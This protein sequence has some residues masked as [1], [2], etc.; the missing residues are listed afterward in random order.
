MQRCRRTNAH[1]LSF[2]DQVDPCL[3]IASLDAGEHEFPSLL[4]TRRVLTP[5]HP[6]RENVST[7]TQQL[8]STRDL[9]FC[10][11]C[12]FRVLFCFGWCFASVSCGAKT[13]GCFASGGALTS[14]GAS[15]AAE[16]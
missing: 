10:S 11:V 12:W 4:Q 13:S 3:T 8:E 7:V 15:G 9:R 6:W 14:C 16:Y 5:L 1:V 2:A